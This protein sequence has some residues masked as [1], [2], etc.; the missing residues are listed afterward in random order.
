MIANLV[1]GI[2][3]CGEKII[4]LKDCLFKLYELG[5]Q[6]EKRKFDKSK[7]LVFPDLFFILEDNE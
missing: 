1:R 6:K 2:N 5:M 7:N 3:Y 4:Y